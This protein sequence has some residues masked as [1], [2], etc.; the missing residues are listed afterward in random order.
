MR[1]DDVRIELPLYARDGAGGEMGG[2][3]HHLDSCPGCREDLR[4]LRETIAL[5]K[6]SAGERPGAELRSAVLGAVEATSLGPLL[7]HATAPP[8]AALKRTVMAAIEREAGGSPSASVTRL[9]PRRLQAA[10][11]LAAAAILVAGVVLGSTIVSDRGPVVESAGPGTIPEGHETQTVALEGAGP[12]TAEVRHYRHDNFRITLSMD[13]FDTTPPGHH[14]AV[15]VR[16]PEGDVAVGTFRLK[17]QDDFEIPF[18]VGV[19]PT[20]YPQLVVSLEPNDG[21]PALTGEVVTEGRFD[22]ATV[23]HGSYD[24]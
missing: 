2:I 11:I 18:A 4:E 3:V 6:E 21:D 15:W 13:G 5:V 9:A 14:Y 24:D 19:N 16:G 20:E 22:P 1:C 12:A 7:A 23:H 17:A 8:P 10:R